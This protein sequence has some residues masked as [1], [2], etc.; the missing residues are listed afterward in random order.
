MKKSQK[1][2]REQ[3]ARI[4]DIKKKLEELKQSSQQLDQDYIF[5]T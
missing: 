3:E 1:E 4:A 5:K 2:L